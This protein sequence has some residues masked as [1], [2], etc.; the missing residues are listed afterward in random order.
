VSKDLTKLRIEDLVPESSESSVES[1]VG[2]PLRVLVFSEDCS[3]CKDLLTKDLLTKLESEG[4]VLVSVEEALLYGADFTDSNIL[5]RDLVVRTPTVIVDRGDFVIESTGNRTRVEYLLF[6][7]ISPPRARRKS[8]E[9]ESTRSTSRSRSSSRRSKRKTP[10]Q[11][12]FLENKKTKRV[13]R[14]ALDRCDRDICVEE[15]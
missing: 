3:T 8:E 10:K 15:A 1:V 2:K 5:T 4:V 13:V 7:R 14:E 12:E 11:E 9:G 6:G